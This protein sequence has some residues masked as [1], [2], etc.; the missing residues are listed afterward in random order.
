MNNKQSVKTSLSVAALALFTLVAVPAFASTAN[1]CPIPNGGSS[2]GNGVSSTYTSDDLGGTAGCNVL[3]T[4]EANGSIV[5]THPNVSSA[6][7]TGND[8]NLVGI[9]NDTGSAITSIHLSSALNDIFGFD[10]DG[11]CGAPGYTFLGGG[12]ACSGV[13]NNAVN[14]YGYGGPGVT[15]SGIS[16]NK[17][18]GIVDFANG[19]I[20]ANGG[21]SFFSLEGP[22]ALDLQSSATP[23]PSSLLLLGT[24]LMTLAGFARRKIR[25]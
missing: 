20:A 24:G 5:T 9:V 11:I 12:N 16:G 1:P 18:S 3:I 17:K 8:D 19:G 23:E 6:Y 15:Y 13:V 21:T 25:A 14:G 4:F 10:E 22:V 2:G 7:D